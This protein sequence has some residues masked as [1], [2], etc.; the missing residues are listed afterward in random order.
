M[1]APLPPAAISHVVAGRAQMGT[2]LS[3]HLFFA[4][5][6][7]GLP[8]MMLVAE[9]MHLRTGDPVWRA[10]ARRWSKV[11]GV[12]FAV[13]AASGTI[14]SFELGLLWPR[15]M[16]YAGGIIGLPFSLEGAAFFLEAIFVGLYLYG[17]DRLAPRV[18]WLI[19]IP[20][21]VS[22]AASAFFVV[23]A[24]AWMNVP[25]GFQLVHGR[26]THVDPLAAMFNPAWA[27]ETSH[28]ILGAYLATTFGV[29][30]VYAVG[31]LRGRQDAYH[32]KA[33]AVALATAAILAPLQVGVGDLLGRTVAANQPAKLAAIEGV[34]HTERN[35]GLNLGGI[36]IPGHP[37][38]IFN[39]KVP[40]L[41]SLLAFDTPNATVR[42]LDT[43]P[44]ADR[45]PLAGPVRLA[46]IGMVGIGT[47]LVGLTLIYW[48]R[49]RRAGSG[50]EYRLTLLALVVAGPLAFL[51]NEL[52]WLVSEFGRQPWIVYGVFRTSSAITTSPG[53]GVTF[54]A[55]TLLYVAL[56]VL[57]I[58]ALRR[59][60]A[61]PVPGL[62][63]PML[64]SA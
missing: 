14:I 22:A 17:W 1:F 16:A 59:L 61:Q 10:L 44:N 39:V 55:F 62:A 53:L 51:A 26:V 34:T 52:G 37:A 50:R 11:F 31:M 40:H 32:R 63:Q 30:S 19:G 35:A 41:L 6:G 46:F 56:S 38:G 25:R 58:W 48:L 18:H 36:P 12:L 64:A 43:F 42:G 54:S 20:I 15:F 21:A 33:I 7:V 13:G 49:R 24:N 5:L 57:T 45:T 2:S 4:V 27:T 29:A 9:G 3:F 60:S 23:T 47:G 8:L 28:M